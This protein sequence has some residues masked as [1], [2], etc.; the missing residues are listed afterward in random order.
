MF[1]LNTNYIFLVGI[2]AYG[3]LAKA[4]QVNIFCYYEYG[5]SYNYFLLENEGQTETFDASYSKN[6]GMGAYKAYV[7]QEDDLAYINKKCGQLSQ[8]KGLVFEKAM[9]ST[10]R[11]TK[12][13]NYYLGSFSKHYPLI[14]VYLDTKQQSMVKEFLSLLPEEHVFS[15]N[16]WNGKSR[17]YLSAFQEKIEN[18]IDINPIENF[19]EEQ[20]LLDFDRAGY[21][22][23][24]GDDLLYS[25][26]PEE[27]FGKELPK[28]A[29]F[30]FLFA[31]IEDATDPQLIKDLGRL[32]L[33]KHIALALMTRTQTFEYEA[34]AWIALPISKYT[35]LKDIDSPAIS[36]DKLV[37]NIITVQGETL[38]LET[39]F[40]IRVTC[41]MILDDAIFL[42]RRQMSVDLRTGEFSEEKVKISK[43]LAF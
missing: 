22:L 37:K 14:G 11:S 43:F 13:Y 7:V 9:A 8:D 12:L 25:H 35:E 19:V 38:I 39:E 29:I 17:K 34:T 33:R 27:N 2:L 3:A 32:Q 41:D 4:E 42:I 16:H 31:A 40:S 24:K 15:V 5:Q 30:D 21:S 23:Y 10:V 6:V 28:Y 20:F 18:L 36:N 26:T 1:R